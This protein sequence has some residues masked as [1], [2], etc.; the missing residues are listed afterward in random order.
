M[1]WSAPGALRIAQNVSSI[2]GGTTVTETIE[3]KIAALKQHASQ[4]RGGDPTQMI[5]EWSTE[6]GGEKEL[7]H[8]ESYR[9]ITLERSDVVD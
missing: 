6:T 3:Q 2:W 1:A 5:I 8:A 7:A 9:V 4:M